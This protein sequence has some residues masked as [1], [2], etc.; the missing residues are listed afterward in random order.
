MINRDEHPITIPS[1]PVEM[2]RFG[3]FATEPVIAS[4]EILQ[5][6]MQAR[7]KDGIDVAF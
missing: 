6:L 2:I 1:S 7:T 3:D 4:D 5:K